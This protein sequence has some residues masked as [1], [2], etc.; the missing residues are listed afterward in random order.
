MKSNQS[1]TFVVERVL[2]MTLE[3]NCK[4]VE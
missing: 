3:P 2:W 1:I 4:I